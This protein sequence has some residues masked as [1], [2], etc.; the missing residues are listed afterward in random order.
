MALQ[1]NADLRLLNGLPESRSV[2]ELSF[3]FVTLHLLISVCTQLR[4]LF[5]AVLL[6]DFPADYYQILVLI[7][8]YY[9]FCWH[10]QSNSTDLFWQMRV[11][12]SKSPNSCS[13]SLLY[14]FLQ[15][16]FTLFPPN[17]LIK[18]FLAKAASRLA[19][20]SFIVKDSVL[21]DAAGLM[22]VLEILFFLHWV[23]IGSLVEEEV[24]N[25]HS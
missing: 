12:I 3:Q 13:N 15:F 6:V 25:V 8:L 7:F 11:I 23:L 14:R 2:F 1:S 4:H 17:I 18:I 5:L 9:P 20:P 10:D 16:S 19:I 22:N 24:H 21:N